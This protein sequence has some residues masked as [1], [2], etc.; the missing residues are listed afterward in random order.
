MRSPSRSNSSTYRRRRGTSLAAAALSFALVAPLAQPVAVGQESGPVADQTAGVPKR[1]NATSDIEA[2][3][4]AIFS[5]GNPENTGTISG[6]VKEIVK[7]DGGFSYVQDSGNALQGVKVFA[8]WYE[9]ETSESV[10]PVYYSESDENGNFTI[11]MAPYVDAGGVNRSFQAEPNFHQ[12]SADA[13][14]SRGSLIEKIRVWTELPE[15]LTDKYRL[16]H[17]PAAAIFPSI[18]VNTTL[19]T[20]GD[21]AWGDFKIT[22]M[23]IQ[24]ARKDKLPQHLPEN[25]W[26]ESV[27]SGGEDGTYAGRAFWNLDVPPGAL[28]LNDVNDYGGKDIPAAGLK[29]VGSYLTDGAVTKIEQYAKENFAGKTPRGSEWTPADEAALQRWINEQVAADPE[30][31]I[32]ETLTTTTGADGT[33]ELRWRGL[34]GNSHTG[35][36]GGL[37]PPADKLHKLAGSHDEGTWQDGDLGSKHVNM[38][39]SY[40]SI[41]DKDG[42]PLPD[43]I[44]VLY[45]WLLGQWGGPSIGFELRSGGYATSFDGYASFIDDTADSYTGW[46]IALV[47]QALKIDVVQKNTTDNFA[48]IGDT[49]QT[50]T[51][52]LPITEDL[53][54][55]IEW[56][57]SWG[58]SVKK[59]DPVNADAATKIPSCELKVPVDAYAGSTFTARLKVT[60]GEPSADDLVLAMDAFA[61]TGAFLDYKEVAAKE[62]VA[63]FSDPVFDNPATADAVEDK[64]VN[65]EFELGASPAGVSADQVAVDP[66]SGVVTFTPT[67][68][69]AGKAF[70]FPVVMRDADLQVPKLDENGDPVLDGEGNP[71]TQAH[72][73]A[74]ADATFNVA[75]LTATTVEPKYEGKLVVPGEETKSSPTFTDKDGK[76]VTAPEGSKFKITDGF[77]VPEGYEVTIDENTGEITVTIPDEFKLNKDTVEVFDVPV[78]VTYPDGSTDKMDADFKLDTDGDGK[79]DTEDGDDDGDGIPDG[80]DSNPKVPNASDHFEPAYEDGFG[81][82]GE[83][84]TADGP[85]FK[86]KDGNPTTVP[87]ST[88][89][90]PG[91][92]TPDGVTIDKNTG[93][94]TVTIPEDATPGDKITV[95]LVVT[96]PD[97]SKDNVD[98]TV[99][100]QPKDPSVIPGENTTVSADNRP[101]EVGKVENPKGDETGKLVD[102]DG[103]E[104]PGSKVEIDKDGNVKVTVPE[105]TDPQDAKVVITNGGDETVGEINVTIVDP[106]E[107]AAKYSP[108]YGDRKNVEAGKVEGVDPF[109]GQTDV[110]VKEAV[111]TPSEGA[112]DWSFETGKDSGVV[113][114]EAPSYEKVGERIKAELPNVN[115]SWAKF[116]EI[117]TPYVR[118]TV[119]VNF[120]YNDGSKNAATAGFELVGK[121]GKSL[122][123]PDGDFDGDGVANHDEIEK[124]SNPAD[125]TS[126]PEVPDTTPPTV[127]PIRPGEKTISGK[128]DRPNETIQVTL[129]DGK[130]IA[131]MTDKDGN[132]KVD[133]PA[134]T[135]LN[136]GDKITVVDEAGNKSA[137]KVQ[138]K[139]GPSEPAAD[140]PEQT[141]SKYVPVYPVSYVRAGEKGTSI[142]PNVTVKDDGFDFTRQPMP[143]GA[144]FSTDYKGASFDEHG[145]LTIMAPKGVDEVV[146]PVTVTF[147]DGTTATT[148]AKFVVSESDAA[149]SYAPA[150]ELGVNASPGETVL[151]HQTGEES[152]PEG[153]EF[154]LVR[155]QSQLNG[156]VVRV[157]SETG[158]IEATA[159]QGNDA[160]RATLAVKVSYFDGS[161]QTIKATVDPGST[162]SMAAKLQ[163][164]KTTMEVGV[165]ETEASNVFSKAP[166]GTKFTL[167]EQVTGDGWTVAIDETTGT[168]TVK[169]DETVKP[170]AKRTVPVQVTL[171][172]GSRKVVDVQVKAVKPDVQKPTPTPKPAP[173][174]SSQSSVNGSSAGSVIGIVVGLLALIGGVGWALKMNEPQIRKVLRDMGIRI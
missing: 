7:G 146:V 80:E 136:P 118:P 123:D 121:D 119:S 65:A 130:V 125:A 131:T 78:T 152:L 8:Q 94:I 110:P 34:Y 174:R 120:E 92:A 173:S 91:E 163:P 36:G 88:T 4:D 171:P 165:G 43:N 147:A 126:I 86:D 167:A 150:Y 2:Y 143:K 27:G 75:E 122:L 151:V 157:N 105:G 58:E 114:A 70:V 51:S 103:N 12:T 74:R 42:N 107:D 29:V 33:F 18:G 52:G 161:E 55:C 153:T 57:D 102:K 112:D 3:K 164:T 85:T 38:Q 39:W 108:N 93:E 140:Q 166:K 50:D 162:D 66:K 69:Q 28:S 19:T 37:N 168:L 71:T 63:A 101:H 129:P 104:I 73:V 124:G 149:E 148:N 54:Y 79:P 53:N 141:A 97:G 24:Y 100:V 26:V 76:D 139:P 59:C 170:N 134:G 135:E 9:G 90:T 81:K 23:T 77:T 44:G 1:A 159:P 155:P 6:S 106:R 47:P 82:P 32:A 138:L 158:V 25:Q 111:G 156:W 115:S 98:V 22:G 45:P 154:E 56:F 48:M 20:Q 67:A 11:N 96:Y 49:I 145:A 14:G 160:K 89:F 64:P 128:D 5:P 132:W 15:D 117:F 99:E 21:S 17:Q 137:A 60:N 40:V 84:V 61:V 142:R 35:N 16:V 41:Y 172:D 10:S 87:D 144:K 68:A 62:G 133:V 30:G 169:T 46:N 113:T 116:K 31:W 72:V 109:E 95:P 127:N 83:D 13:W